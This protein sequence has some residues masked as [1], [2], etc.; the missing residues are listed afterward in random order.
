MTGVSVHQRYKCETPDGG[1][2]PA[3]RAD[4]WCDMPDAVKQHF[5]RT[6]LLRIVYCIKYVNP[7]FLGT[8]QQV[9]GNNRL[10]ADS[11]FQA[12]LGFNGNN[13]TVARQG[14]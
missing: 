14:Q 2:L 12:E 5:K 4:G 7:L 1:V 8:G 11:G 13:I 6:L 3:G 10:V 9:A